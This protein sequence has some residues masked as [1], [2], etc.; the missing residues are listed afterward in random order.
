[1]IEGTS[2][3]SAGSTV[4][5]ES[6]GI[7]EDAVVGDSGEE[8]GRYGACS[9][10]VT[11]SPVTPVCVGSVGRAVPSADEEVGRTEDEAFHEG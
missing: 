11:G 5:E 7:A 6:F 10:G 8:A 4:V 9:T 2:V 3:D 1:M